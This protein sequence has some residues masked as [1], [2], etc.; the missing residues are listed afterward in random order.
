M[1][2]RY[3]IRKYH[4]GAASVLLGTALVLGAAAQTVQAEEQNSETAS[5]VTIDTVEKTAPITETS[6]LNTEN[7]YAA[8]SVATPVETTPEVPVQPT[9][10]KPVTPVTQTP[11]VSTTVH[12]NH[13]EQLPDTGSQSDYISVLLGSGILLSL[14]VGRRKE[15]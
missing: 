1:Q 2:Q 9:P 5:S 6:T 8:P 4:F 15:D 14:Y 10:A 11:E 3:S 7:T 13:G 12:E